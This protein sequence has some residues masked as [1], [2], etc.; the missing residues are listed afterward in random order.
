MARRYVIG[1]ENPICQH[2]SICAP[3]FI[4]QRTSISVR[5]AEVDGRLPAPLVDDAAGALLSV[6]TP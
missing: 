4:E 6:E 1:W 3:I 5:E 2:E